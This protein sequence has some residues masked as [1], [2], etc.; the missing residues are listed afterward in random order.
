MAHERILVIKLGALGDVMMNTGLIRAVVDRHPGAEFTLMTHAA[1]IPLMRQSGWFSDFIVDNRK[2]YRFS[3]LKRICHDELALRRYDFIYD[4]Q[5][6]HRT[7]KVYYPLVRFLTRNPLVWGFTT[8]EYPLPR[9]IVF[10][11]TPAKR[12]FSW[13]RSTVERIDVDPAPPDIGF[14]HGEGKHF[15]LLPPRY[16]LLIPGCSPTNPGKRWPADRYRALSERFGAMG[17]KSVVLGTSAEQ[18][19]INAVVRDNPHAVDFMNKA[20][21]T[22][23]PDLARGAEVVVGNDTGP[24]HMARL[25]GARSVMLFNA[26]TREAAVEMP[27][28]VNLD[29]RE[30]ADI[31]LEAVVSA[32]KGLLA[33]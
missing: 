24:T 18:A 26:H 10:N 31:P 33:P 19:E 17:L 11:R 32:V 9:G 5:T 21:L 3:E 6:S 7:C 8:P 16:L 15:D 22:D 1:I 13:G 2:G 29:A 27:N 20:S 23:I 28:V 25:A 14:V 4:L 12:A 30:I